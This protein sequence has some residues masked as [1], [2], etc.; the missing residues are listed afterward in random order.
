MILACLTVSYDY[1]YPC[2]YLLARPSCLTHLLWYSG[3]VVGLPAEEPEV[4]VGEPQPLVEWRA[5][6]VV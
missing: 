2:C 6:D 3:P 4:A 1:A 5:D